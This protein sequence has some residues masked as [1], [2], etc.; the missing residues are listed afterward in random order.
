[1]FSNLQSGILTL[2]I[3]SNSVALSQ[4]MYYYKV[5]HVICKA[6]DRFYTLNNMLAEVMLVFFAGLSRLV[7]SCTGMEAFILLL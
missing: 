1:M 2:V 7:F 5:C 3:C 4:K 6:E